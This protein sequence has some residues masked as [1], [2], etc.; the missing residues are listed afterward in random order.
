M[1]H[2]NTYVPLSRFYDLSGWSAPIMQNTPGGW[3]SA[4]LPDHQLLPVNLSTVVSRLQAQKRATSPA[5]AVDRLVVGRPKKRPHGAA[6]SIVVLQQ[7]NNAGESFDWLLFKL[8]DDWGLAYTTMLPAE[9]TVPGALDGADVLLVPH[10]TFTSVLNGLGE[11]GQQAIIDWVARGGHYVGWQGGAQLSSALGVSMTEFVPQ[12]IVCPGSFV[13]ALVDVTHPLAAGVGDE[14]F[15][16]YRDN[17]PLMRSAQHRLVAFFPSGDSEDW[18]VSG[19]HEG[20]EELGNAVGVHQRVTGDG[21]VTSFAF[22]VN[23]RAFTAGTSKMIHNAILQQGRRARHNLTASARFLPRSTAD[24]AAALTNAPSQPSWSPGRRDDGGRGEG[25]LAVDWANHVRLA[26]RQPPPP[27]P[28]LL[29][30]QPPASASASASAAVR[31]LERN[32]TLALRSLGAGPPR[33][34]RASPKQRIYSVPKSLAAGGG[35]D[36][37]DRA[38][39]GRLS[40]ALRTH[41]VEPVHIRS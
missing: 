11:T 5:A 40:H 12:D 33:F 21:L 36:D 29:P 6:G 38:W 35:V 20:A 2:E 39:L 16:Y 23:F 41:V 13:R 30:Q 17:M 22:E 14:L 37:V 18:F 19:Y 9:F 24:R 32:L 34:V 31:A 8:R 1:L 15:M 10:V 26:V 7:S 4:T 3:S 28:P 25:E 27:P